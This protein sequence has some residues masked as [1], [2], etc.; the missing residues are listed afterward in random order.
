LKKKA[1]KDRKKQLSSFKL[2]TSK[3][4]TFLLFLNCTAIEIFTGWV[5][6]NNIKIAT[7]LMTPPDLSPLIAL[8]GAVVGET[9]GFAIYCIKAAKEN[10]KGGIIY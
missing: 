4:L 10:C 8:I 1:L 9:I 7:I 5:I 3:L 6:I 2:T